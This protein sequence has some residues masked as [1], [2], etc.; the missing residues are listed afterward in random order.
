MS[1]SVSLFVSLSLFVS[2]TWTGQD[3]AW[4][5]ICGI[6]LEYV[7]RVLHPLDIRQI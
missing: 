3:D 1:I 6:E 2:A 4:E 5:A 7:Q